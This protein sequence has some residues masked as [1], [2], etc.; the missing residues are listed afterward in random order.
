MCTIYVSFFLLSPHWTNI[1]L[2]VLPLN[3]VFPNIVSNN[4]CC[5]LLNSP[6]CACR[7]LTMIWA[8]TDMVFQ[9][10]QHQLGRPE[11]FLL[12][13]CVQHPHA[14]SPYLS[15]ICCYTWSRYSWANHYSF[16]DTLHIF[17]QASLDFTSWISQDWIQAIPWNSQYHWVFIFPLEY[18]QFLSLLLHHPLKKTDMG[19]RW[20]HTE[21]FLDNHFVLTN[22]YLK[23]F[24]RE[25]FSSRKCPIMRI[26]SR[27]CFLSL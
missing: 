13:I 6:Q 3:V 23:R 20:N 10:C 14:V 18:L 26:L 4:F 16:I 1:S 7:C 12:D 5:C 25:L 2:P 11:G 9:L 17:C 21:V 8:T 15:V 24:L 27:P 19:F 22:P